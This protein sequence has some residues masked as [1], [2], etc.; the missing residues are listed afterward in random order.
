[1]SLFRH[2]HSSLLPE[3]LVAFYVHYLLLLLN[4]I[5]ERPLKVGISFKRW[6]RKVSSE[7]L[8]CS[9]TRIYFMAISR[10]VNKTA[11]VSITKDD[12]S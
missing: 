11:F 4:L 6:K 10:G 3:S 1:M 5:S 8:L 12:T 9:H 2:G 7:L